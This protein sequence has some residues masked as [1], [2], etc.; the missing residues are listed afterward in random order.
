MKASKELLSNAQPL[1]IGRYSYSEPNMKG[2]IVDIEGVDQK[3]TY[4]PVLCEYGDEKVLAFRCEERG[5]DIYDLSNYHP[6][7]L[8]ARFDGSNFQY[9]KSIKAFDM[10]E[11]P[12]F[13]RYDDNGVKGIIFGGVMARL[14]SEGQFEV[15]TKFFK[16]LSLDKIDRQPFAVIKGM[17]DERL[18]Q[19][20]DGRFLL[21]NRPLDNR[22]L[23]RV[24]AHII[25]SL[26]ELE[27][28]GSNKL[29]T[30]FE[31]SGL[32]S[33]DW[34]GVNGIYILEDDSETLWVGLLGHVAHC[35]ELGQKHYAA[36]TY[37]IKLGDLMCGN[38]ND[39]KPSVI[40]TRSCFEDGPTKN[41][42]LVDVVFPGCLEKI[43]DNRYRLWAGLSD[44]RIGVIELD[45]PF[46]LNCL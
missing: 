17:K 14:V 37:K 22:G 20:P 23:G 39:M 12:L 45:D 35:D 2:L 42:K 30:V 26:D 13:C 46:K 33:D 32:H 7:V 21:C 40:A 41:D 11:D 24:A 36:T 44:A 4:N 10:M 29:P 6:S 3:D 25:D 8:F 5:S 1:W 27:L 38:C 28:A 15:D 34:V 16:G 43:G 31:L 9:D 19:L 18:A